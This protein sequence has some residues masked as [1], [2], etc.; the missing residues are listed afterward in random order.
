MNRITE[1]IFY[2]WIMSLPFYQFSIIGTLSLDNVLGPLLLLIWFVGRPKLEP[3]VIN[4]QPKVIVFSGLI[5][6]IYFFSHVL[7]LVMSEHVIWKSIYGQIS[8]LTYF[9]VPLFYLR[10]IRVQERTQD[11]I[12]LITMIGA[13]SA[14]LS[15]I[16]LINLEGVRYSTSRV[17]IEGLD[18]TRT[19]GL[20]SV[21]GDMAILSSFTIMLAMTSKRNK[22]LFVKRSKA[23]V[24]AVFAVIILGLIGSQ[25]RN[26]VLT[27]VIAVTLYVVVTT[28][29]KKGVSW[30][31]RFYAA[32]IASGLSAIIIL[33][34][35]WQPI[36]NM[37]SG[38]G[39]EQAAGTALGRLEQYKFALNL[40]GSNPFVGVD[41][42]I[43]EKYAHLISGIHNMWLKELLQGGVFSILAL[44]GL[45]VY[46]L[47]NASKC[48]YQN[49]DDSTAKI[50]MVMMFAILVSTQFNPSG[51]SIFWFILGYS[52]A[53]VCVPADHGNEASV[54]KASNEKAAQV[55]ILKK[56][57]RAALLDGD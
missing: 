21:Y 20:F 16:G 14:F 36:V 49:S 41:L 1:I 13:I 10:N 51:T 7:T 22:L 43:Y 40:V 19:V 53:I 34:F 18:L 27:I 46:C 45:I 44:L 37:V 38:W 4:Q 3:G 57:S 35:F 54:P 5:L 9:F 56:R 28:L 33:T 15:S 50:K 42:E 55:R 24:I 29:S 30:M 6:T 11:F 25:S 39:G 31:P 12:V 23:I 17:S 2:I 26:M 8:D 32:L 47:R 48:L 52:V